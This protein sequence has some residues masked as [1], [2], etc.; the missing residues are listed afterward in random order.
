VWLAAFLGQFALGRTEWRVPGALLVAAALQCAIV[1]I[2]LISLY[3]GWRGLPVSAWGWNRVAWFL[4]QLLALAVAMHHLQAL[5]ALSAGFAPHGLHLAAHWFSALLLTIG[6]PVALVSVVAV[7][8]VARRSAARRA[9]DV[10]AVI[11]GAATLSLLCIL[12]GALHPLD[13]LAPAFGMAWQRLTCFLL[14]I[15]LVAAALVLWA[16]SAPAPRQTQ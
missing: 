9:P 2:P 15:A 16:R 10:A 4:S 5:R 6:I 13:R 7:W 11:Y 3:R 14:P 12:N 8:M 1:I